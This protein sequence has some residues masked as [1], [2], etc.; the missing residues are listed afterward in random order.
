MDLSNVAVV[1]LNWNGK[2]FLEKFLPDVIKH[3]KQASI[4]LADNLS[5]DDSVEFVKSNFP[6]IKIIQ[7][8]DN[9]G[10]AEGYNQALK[11]VSEEYYVLLNSDVEVTANWIEPIIALMAERRDIAACQPKILD[12]YQ[13]DTFEYAGASG[14]Y[15]DKYAY[16]FCRGRIFNNLEK[17][18][19]QYDDAK[20]VFWATG[21]CMFVRASAFWK[22]QG[23][24]GDYFAHM[25]E[26]D[27]CWRL[28]NI[29]YSVFVQPQSVVYHVGGGTLNKL[30][31]KKT[32]LNFR[33]NLITLTKNSSPKMLWLKILYRLVLDGIA[34]MKFL[35]EGHGSHF[36]AVI[37]A[38]FSFYAH[39]PSTLQKRKNMKM[40]S[41]FSYATS[42]VLRKNI[43]F[44]HFIK[45]I[46]RY[47]ELS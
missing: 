34:G 13:R 47:S 21:A 4:Y 37:K 27:L 33:N 14:G 43:V 18:H 16:P 42:G 2:S 35:L 5:S 11:H 39:L 26:I 6:V 22:I 24:D 7:N 38:H 46:K 28:K 1:I 10:Y 12:F 44:T 8:P 9:K 19:H 41:H 3:S 32:F 36:V 25:E 15:I 40:M 20:E 31:P 23:F 29:G 30:S 17:D 45:G